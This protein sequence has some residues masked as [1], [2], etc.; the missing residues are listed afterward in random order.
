LLGQ[1]DDVCAEG[2]GKK[3]VVVQEKKVRISIEES[4]GNIAAIQG[5]KSERHYF[6]YR[7]AGN[8]TAIDRLTLTVY[9]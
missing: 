5:M 3:E 4:K 2:V 9:K 7:A 6:S 8:C 1:V